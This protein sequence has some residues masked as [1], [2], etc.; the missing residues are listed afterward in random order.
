MVTITVHAPWSHPFKQHNTE[1]YT[2]LLHRLCYS[3]NLITVVSFMKL[4]ILIVFD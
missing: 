4:L 2:E 3:Y 1:S